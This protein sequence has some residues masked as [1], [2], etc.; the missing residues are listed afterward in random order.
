M[1]LIEFFK[2]NGPKIIYFLF[3]LVVAPF[4]YF[5][6]S[7]TLGQ[8]E[9]KWIWG[10]PPLVSLTYDYLPSSLQEFNIGIF[11]I[12]QIK[13]TYYWIPTYALFIFLLSCVIGLIVNKIKVRY[14]ITTFRGLLWRKLEKTETKPLEKVEQ[15]GKIEKKEEQLKEEKIEEKKEEVK[16]E[17]IKEMGEKKIE[18]MA[19]VIREEESLLKEQKKELQKYLDETN[20]K[21]LKSMGVDMKENKILCSGCKQ[22]KTIPKRK[23]M[24][25]IQEQGF[26][27]IWEYKCPECQRKK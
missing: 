25:L 9:V 10:F 23:L 12:S 13:T 6:F 20:I 11:E 8:Y 27:I 24:K 7:E 17:E 19:K 16:P 4:P 15:P 18:E 22:W 1:S 14:N 5:I 2:P 26:D 3:L 21:R